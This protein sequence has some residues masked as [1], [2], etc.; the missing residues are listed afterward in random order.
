MKLI[1]TVVLF[2]GVVLCT[3][4]LYAVGGIS[5]TKVVVPSTDTVPLDTYEIEPFLSLQVFDDEDDT[6]FFDSGLRFTRGFLNNLEA[7]IS[8]SILTYEDSDLVDS[9]YNFGDIAA[10]VK[11]RFYTL[12]GL[13]L[14]YQ[15]GFTL[16]TSTD[17]TNWVFE[18]LGLIL[19]LKFMN[20]ISVDAD[21][22][23][24][25]E[26][27]EIFSI[28]S[29]LGFG[30][31]VTEIFQPVIELGYE[32]SDPDDFSSSDILSL[33]GGF[34]A[35]LNDSMT[36]IVGVTKDIVSENAPDSYTLSSALTVAF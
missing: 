11:Y 30:M 29:N 10:G 35:N 25:F 18:P 19:T 31:F 22:V 16:P 28:V 13:S 12:S 5:N 26:E 20:N 3:Q 32:Y 15:G 21:F 2:M 34:T 8:A 1:L 33:T 17:D 7:G 6:K 24:V 9:D 23:L 36:L 14:A 27:S 4:D